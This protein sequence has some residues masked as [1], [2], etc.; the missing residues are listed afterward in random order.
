M[1]LHL[2]IGNMTLQEWRSGWS[3]K[4]AKP[5]LGLLAIEPS[6]HDA[7]MFEQP[8]RTAQSFARLLN[9]K[10]LATS[11]VH[12]STPVLN[13]AAS[14]PDSFNRDVALHLTRI[15]NEKDASYITV[16]T[17]LNRS[18]AFSG[19]CIQFLHETAKLPL[20]AINA[21]SKSIE[22][23]DRILVPT[24]LS[25]RARDAFSN[26]IALASELKADIVLFMP[27][28]L[29]L[30]SRDDDTLQTVAAW[31]AD[32]QRQSVKVEFVS[33]KKDLPVTASILGHAD[34]HDC[35]LIALGLL[36]TPHVQRRSS[37]L[38]TS[39]LKE[40]RIP[41]LLLAGGAA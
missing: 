34:K 13:A 1:E 29:G 24:D 22:R 3:M 28:A 14:Q 2:G 41:V 15:A 17:H 32:G 16:L 5:H 36:P 10:L 33:E 20:L 12:A 4:T 11:V 26:V 19:S 6:R 23:F 35:N 8:L 18:S 21:E 27:F 9:S 30:N 38:A 31:I 25:A 7:S 40:S 39:V 37:T